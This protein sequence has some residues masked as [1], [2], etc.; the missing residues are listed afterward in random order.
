ME[1][2]VIDVEIESTEAENKL[3]Q[4]ELIEFA[5]KYQKKNRYQENDI[6]PV[7]KIN[8][9]TKEHFQEILCPQNEIDQ[10]IYMGVPLDSLIDGVLSAWPEHYDDK[11]LRRALERAKEKTGFSTIESVW[12]GHRLSVD[13]IEEVREKIFRR[14]RPCENNSKIQIYV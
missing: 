10:K 5:N 3:T 1:N 11:A 7:E 9:I 4:A 2:N 12:K 6:V 8:E 14:I 13:E